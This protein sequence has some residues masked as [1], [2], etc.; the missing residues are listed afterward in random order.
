MSKNEF[1]KRI[2][3]SLQTQLGLQRFKISLNKCLNKTQ[4]KKAKI[5]LEMKVME[6][7]KEPFNFNKE[8]AKE[9]L[10]IS[11][12]IFILE[13]ANNV[14]ISK[15]NENISK[16]INKVTLVEIINK[17][18]DKKNIEHIVKMKQLEKDG[19]DTKVKQENASVKQYKSILKYIKEFFTDDFDFLDLTHKKAEEFRNFLIT[20]EK[21]MKNDEVKN[22]DNNTINIYFR[23]L[24]TISK[25]YIVDNDLNINNPFNNF[26]PL[27]ISENKKIFKYDEIKQLENLL[28][29][30]EYLFF[31]FLTLSGL[32][33]EEMIAIKKSNIIDNCLV[34]LDAKK[35]F[36]KVVPIHNDIL[37]QI[38]KEIE[39]LS[40]KQYL[41]FT[42]E[43]NDS[44]LYK[45]SKINYI[46][47]ENFDKTLHKTRA[48]FITYL[49]YYNTNFSDNDIRSL[50]HKVDGVDN[51][52]YV[53]TR[54]VDNLR[55]IVYSINLEKLNDISNI[56]LR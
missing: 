16:K 25:N 7:F 31:K 2:P 49:N 47:K 28:T 3:E 41:F 5:F 30:E 53:L 4:V 23:Q 51:K 1:I 54:N 17:A 19:V 42:F 33:F 13:N 8:K 14:N 18:I 29:N 34:F 9:Y 56:A 11:L 38:N 36:K 6:I 24:K 21:E 50:T 43:E 44:R 46:L 26:K 22:I 12:N 20:Y 52:N 48:T 27:P 15:V 55:N 32:R 40:D 37:E 45:R 35:Q 10:K 39:N